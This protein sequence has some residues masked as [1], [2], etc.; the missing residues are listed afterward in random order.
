MTRRYKSRPIK[1]LRLSAIDKTN[2]RISFKKNSRITP[3]IRP[4]LLQSSNKCLKRSYSLNNLRRNHPLCVK[5]N[6]RSWLTSNPI[7][8]S[9]ILC[10]VTPQQHR[11]PGFFI[12]RKNRPCP[13]HI[14]LTT[15]KTLSKR[16]SSSLYGE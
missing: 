3:S 16:N 10:S 2:S 7:K 12:T 4:F 15:I 5:N 11:S 8:S 14:R 1:R 6:S 9:K 13:L